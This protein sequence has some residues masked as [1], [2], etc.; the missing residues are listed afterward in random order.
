MNKEPNN[1]FNSLFEEANK[2]LWSKTKP[3]L[4]IY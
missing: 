4:Q 2:P 1:N 3:D